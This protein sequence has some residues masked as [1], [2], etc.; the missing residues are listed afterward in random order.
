MTLLDVR[1][2]KTPPLEHAKHLYFWPCVSQEAWYTCTEHRSPHSFPTSNHLSLSLRSHCWY[3]INIPTPSL[4]RGRSETFS[5]PGCLVNKLLLCCKPRRLSIRLAARQADEPG[6]V[7]SRQTEFPVCPFLAA[8]SLCA[9]VWSTG[10]LCADANVL[11][12][13]HSILSLLQLHPQFPL[14]W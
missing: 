8:E 6:L 13:W 9:S 4:S 12:S 7:T 5:S 1:G 3:L 11:G 14:G 2:S 10:I